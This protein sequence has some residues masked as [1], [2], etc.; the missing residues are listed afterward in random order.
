MIDKTIFFT[1][2]LDF[3][4]YNKT[5]IGE[6]LLVIVICLIALNSA[7]KLE[8]TTNRIIVIAGDSVL[9]LMIV[10]Q[11]IIRDFSKI[12]HAKEIHQIRLKINLMGNFIVKIR[13]KKRKVRI[14]GL[15]K[16]HMEVS[17]YLDFAKI[18]NLHIEFNEKKIHI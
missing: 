2:R 4:K 9:M 6:F 17:K 1:D 7:L 15:G 16:N 13:N 5:L 3:T 12:T 10:L 18:N 8:L 14:V 11:F